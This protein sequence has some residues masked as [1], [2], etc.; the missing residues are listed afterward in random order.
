MNHQ[1][2]LK[3]VLCT[4]ALLAATSCGKSE[5]GDAAD[6]GCKITFNIREPETQDN[7]NWTYTGSIPDSC[8]T[9]F[10]EKKGSLTLAVE[11]KGI[12]DMRYTLTQAKLSEQQEDMACSGPGRPSGRDR[13]S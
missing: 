9:L 6:D 13:S 7:T 11:A 1:N 2:R 5:S 12:E 3:F 10:A 8:A 4:A